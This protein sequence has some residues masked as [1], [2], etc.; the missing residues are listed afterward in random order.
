[1]KRYMQVYNKFV[2][3][4]KKG[5]LKYGDT[6]PSIR[7]SVEVFG[8]S[9]T[10]IERGYE[11]L[12]L[13]GYIISEAQKGFIVDIKPYQLHRQ[14]IIAQ[15]SN[16]DIPKQYFYD[17]RSHAVSQ[18]SFDLR[19]WKRYMKDVFQDTPLISTYGDKQG[20]QELRTALSEYAYHN[21]GILAT[22]AQI[23]VGSGFQSLLFDFCSLLKK[24]ISIAMEE[25]VT[26]EVLHVFT[27]FGFDCHFLSKERYIEELSLLDIDILYINTAC[28]G[29]DFAPLSNSMRDMILQLSYDNNFLIL[30]DDY[31]GELTYHS[32]PR[33]ALQSASVMDNVIYFSSFSRLLLPSLR[34][35]Y[36]IL[37]IKYQHAYQQFKDSFGPTASKLEQL[38]LARY[39]ANGYLEKHVRKLKREYAKKEQITYDLLSSAG[40]SVLLQEAYFSYQI[41]IS[42][43]DVFA[44]IKACEEKG[45]GIDAPT[46]DRL[47]VSFA[48]L[49]R[50][51]L[52]EGLKLLVKI[53]KEC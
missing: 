9:K 44:I 32:K 36:M 20:E 45:I 13:D 49:D 26:K 11:Q 30:E 16:S 38:V 33:Q 12:V 34:L 6:L 17:F 35:S 19:V 5:Y 47:N 15:A 4:I 42:H 24:P 41:D 18:D 51:R 48:Y 52:Q 22:G 31:N 50:D 25:S 46:K 27:S 1:M 53:L 29:Q 37:N 28:F 7:K 40:F 8:F 10:S 21:R 43:C 23:L 39:I 3:D 14:Q 2:E